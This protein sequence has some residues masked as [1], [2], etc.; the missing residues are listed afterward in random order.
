MQFNQ[1]TQTLDE[2]Q[3]KAKEVQNAQ[4]NYSLEARDA[5]EKSMNFFLKSLDSNHTFGKSMFYLAQLFVETP[6]RYDDVSYD[7]LPEAFNLKQDEYRHVIEE[8]KGSLDLMPFEEAYLREDLSMVYSE[9]ITNENVKTKLVLLQGVLD[10]IT[11]LK[12]SFVY[13]TEKNSYKLVAKLYYNMI[14][15]MQTLVD[16]IPDKKEEIRELMDQYYNSFNHWNNKTIEILPGGWN[17]FPEWE[18]TYAEIISM[19]INLLKYIDNEKIMQNIFYFMGKDGWA[20]YHMANLNRG[21]PD[22]SL[23]ILQDLYFNIENT[24]IKKSLVDNVVNSYKDVYNYYVNLSKDSNVYIRYKN[25][26]ESFLESYRYF[27][28][29]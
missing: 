4:S 14:L 29:R 8:Y 22:S 15:Q 6:Y 7:D 27:Q 11:Y 3:K 9:N 12:T 10:E 20:N 26:I 24:N 23:S 1:I 18:N 13:F 2:I 5:Y 17:R 21:I 16:S 19:N 25:R 28:R